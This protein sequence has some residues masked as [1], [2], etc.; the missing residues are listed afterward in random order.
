[1]GTGRRL[2]RRPLAD[3]SAAGGSQMQRRIVVAVAAAGVFGAA[4]RWG[5]ATQLDGNWA[6]LVANVVGCGV[7]GW[8]TARQ[9]ANHR[10][11][12]PRQLSTRS[13]RQDDGG[14]PW[15]T[16]GFCGALTSMSALALQLARHLNDGRVG[17]AA[18]WLGLTIAACTSA[19]VAG[20]AAVV[21]RRGRP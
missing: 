21:I 5:L 3:H 14:S 1:M 16:A 2:Q 15:L 9:H 4:V 12:R 18:A 6:L 11:V 8:A 20:R 17:T 10:R 13:L 19:F 7:V